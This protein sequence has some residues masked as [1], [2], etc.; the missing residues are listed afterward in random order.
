VK[1]RALAALKP[2]LSMIL[3]LAAILVLRHEFQ[4]YRPRDVLAQ[5]K[6]IPSRTLIVALLLT[7]LDYLTLTGYD[8]LAFRYVRNP[9]PYRRIALSSFVSYAIGHNLSP[10][11]GSATRYRMLSTWG[12]Q[13]EDIARIIAFGMLTFW[14]GLLFLG[15]MV[16]TV[17][18]VS[19]E[20]PGLRLTSSR[21]IGVVLLAVLGVYVAM[22]AQR[23]GPIR[24]RGFEIAAPGP[25]ITAAQLVISSSDWLVASL[26]LYTILPTSPELSFPI[27]LGIYLLAVVAGLVSHVPGGLGVFE[28]AMV[29]LLAA[30][31]PGDQVLAS[32]VAYRVIYYLL[33]MVLAVFLLTAYEVRQRRAHLGRAA[34]TARGWLAEVTPRLLAASTFVAGAVLLLSG[35]SPELPERLAWLRNALPLPLIEISKLLGSVFGVLLL[36]LANALRQ[37]IDAAYYGALAL[38]MGGAVASLLKGLDWEEA[39]LLATMGLALAPCRSFFYRRSSLLTQPLSPTWWVAVIAV[40]AGSA[41]TLELAYRHVEYSNDLWW[42]FGEAEQASRSL[43]AMLAAGIVF[44][45]LGA[46]R[47]LR[48]VPPVPDRPTPEELDRVAAIMSKS[49]RVNGYLALLGDKELL[50]HEDGDAFLMF[51]IS[52]RTWVAMGD[53][54]GSTDQQEELAWRFRELADRHGARAVFYEVSEAAL[55]IYLDLGLELRKL[56]EEGR[57]PLQSFSLEGS[58]RKELRQA[59][60]RMDRE[61]VSFEIVPPSGV[62]PLLDELEAVSSA[63]L[64]EKNT[65]EKGFSLGFFDRQYLA[66]LPVAVVRKASRIVAFANIWPSAAKVE[67]TIDLMRYDKS[68]P[69]RVMEYL[70]TQLMLW[71][72]TE[73]YQYFSLGMAPLSGFESRRLT[74][75]W[76]RFGAFLFRHGEHFYNFQGLRNFKEKFNPDWEPRYLAT[77]RNISVPFVLTRIAGLVSGGVSGVLAK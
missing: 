45:V 21:A 47:L 50:F 27:F 30:Y 34:A 56:G 18:P 31:L 40:A 75:L 54:I 1:Q 9:L 33:P 20:L 28:T 64:S 49:A 17:W 6:N 36:I 52:G 16:H 35:A 39:T 13:T 29:L 63:W 43:R 15:G 10:F 72:R 68:A 44:L 3:L 26:V 25:G 74:P 11:G 38:L 19:M 32:I 70:F 2:M 62:V 60:N 55:P 46:A 5:L 57:V 24:L 65:R 58:S 66:R 69:P 76:N 37:R 48:P 22:V 59:L 71:G 12:V 7:A 67:L 4:A 53:P 41:F 42:R 14:L 61:E 51:G 8:A 77:P 23:R 73:G